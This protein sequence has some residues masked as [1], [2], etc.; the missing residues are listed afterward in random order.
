[1]K[2]KIKASENEKTETKKLEA[3]AGVFTDFSLPETKKER[4]T[5]GEFMKD[6][7]EVGNIVRKILLASSQ[8]VSLQIP[9]HKAEILAGHVARLFKLY[10]TYIFLIVEKRTEVAFV[11]LRCLTETLINFEYLLKYLDT[12]I[13]DKYKRASLSF[14][15]DLKELVLS[16]L[17]KGIVPET[18]QPLPH[19]ILKSIEE[20]FKRSAIEEDG[21]NFQKKWGIKK[22]H[23]SLEGKAKDLGLERVYKL[24]FQNTSAC[25]H[26]S[27]HDIDFYH[28]K[29]EKGESGVRESNP[30]FQEPRPQ[31]LSP[32]TLVLEAVMRY[33]GILGVSDFNP[34]IQEIINWFKEMDA[35]HED[36]LVQ[37]SIGS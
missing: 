7:V 17:E 4:K 35:Q 3:M 22:E 21:E 10:D 8:A 5:E 1:M 34:K 9:A 29:R 6:L 19:R 16:D 12:D 15:R 11:I 28:L 30:K 20:T 24:I 33:W 37:I 31:M 36:F 32:S 13:F 14:E 25:I 23:L 27:W 2:E 18:L 26:G